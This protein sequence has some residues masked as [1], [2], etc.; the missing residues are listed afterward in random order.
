MSSFSYKLKTGDKKVVVVPPLI[1]G[2]LSSHDVRMMATSSSGSG[3]VGGGGGGG[4][5]GSGGSGGGRTDPSPVKGKEK[6]TEGNAA[7]PYAARDGRPR[8]LCGLP[9]GRLRSE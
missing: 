9:L 1:F 8:L 4:G 2:I 7:T 6:K 5:S 3:G